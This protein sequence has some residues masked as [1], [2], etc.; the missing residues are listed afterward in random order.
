VRAQLADVLAAAGKDDAAT[1]EF[2]RVIEYAPR[3]MRGY[4]GLAALHMRSERASPSFTVMR[5]ALDIDPRQEQE[6][7]SLTDYPWSQSDLLGYADAFAKGTTAVANRPLKNSSEGIIRYHA[8]NRPAARALFNRALADDRYNH[9]ALLYLS[10]MEWEDGKGNSVQQM[11]KRAIDTTAGSHTV[12]QLYLAR[13]ELAGGQ[14]AESKRRLVRILDGEPT[15]VQARF[16]LGQ[17]HLE[18]K[19]SEEALRE[20]RVIIEQAPDYLPVKRAITAL[21]EKS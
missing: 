13:A 15:L 8:G 6:R 12:T 3:S 4:F 10:V 18:Q 17:L 7:L 9:P 5:K 20:W 11:L 14:V 1:R 21:R 2:S 19:A 16:T